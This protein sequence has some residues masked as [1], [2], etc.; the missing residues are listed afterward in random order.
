M[1]HALYAFLLLCVVALAAGCSGRFETFAFQ[2][3]EGARIDIWQSPRVAADREALFQPRADHAASPVYHLARAITVETNGVSFGL[4]YTSA[5][6]RT[7]LPL[8]VS[9]T[10][11]PKTWK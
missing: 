4:S 11:I 2:T 6:P 8:V 5:V 7:T 10:I 3:A 9:D 1:K